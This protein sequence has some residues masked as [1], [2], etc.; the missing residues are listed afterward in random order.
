MKQSSPPRWATRLLHRFGNPDEL[1]EIEGDL[2]ELYQRWV[3]QYGTKKA[4]WL[5]A[6][7]V[8]TFLRPFA[9]RRKE[10][11]NHHSTN[12]TAMFSSYLK[13]TYRRLIRKKAFA[14]INIVGLAVSLAA[15]LDDLSVRA[16]RTE[17]RSV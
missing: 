14:L 3:E 1:L 2:H 8:I 9:V 12:Q 17:L 15:A 10:K 16:A 6:I 13:I 11:N 4:Q 7:N 5:Y